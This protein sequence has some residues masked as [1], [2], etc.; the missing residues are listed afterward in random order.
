MVKQV[1]LWRQELVVEL[2][3]AFHSREYFIREWKVSEFRILN[4][5]PRSG[6][7]TVTY[8]QHPFSLLFEG[9]DADDA[10]KLHD[11]LAYLE[12]AGYVVERQ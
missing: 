2:Y 1:F 10:S 9:V 8:S 5:I 6:S 12:G 11:Y 3:H 7:G 4:T